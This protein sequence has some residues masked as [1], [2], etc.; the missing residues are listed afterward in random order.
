MQQEKAREKPQR[1]QPEK[2]Q[3]VEILQAESSRIAQAQ[4][5]TPKKKEKKLTTQ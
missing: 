2:N 5:K 3:P 4:L 1:L